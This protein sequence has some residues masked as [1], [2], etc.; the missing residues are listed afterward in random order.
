[1]RFFFSVRCPGRFILCHPIRL[2]NLGP[3]TKSRAESETLLHLAACHNM[4][5]K[6]KLSGVEALYVPLPGGTV[7]CVHSD[8]I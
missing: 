1:M 6:C 5:P 3:Q 7:L 8:Y 4:K 2:S